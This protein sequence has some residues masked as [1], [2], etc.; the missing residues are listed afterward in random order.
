MRID[1]N[2][3][4]DQVQ[5]QVVLAIPT[6]EPVLVPDPTQAPIATATPTPTP[7]PTPAPTPRPTATPRPT[8]TVQTLLWQWPTA[9]QGQGSQSA[10]D[11]RPTPE[12]TPT[13]EPAATAEYVVDSYNPKVEL[14]QGLDFEV[15]PQPQPL[16][17]AIPIDSR[18]LRIWPIVLII[19]GAIMEVV[20]IGMF[21]RGRTEAWIG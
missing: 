5:T 12:S 1:I 11:S 10:P 3:V 8:P 13:R 21:V 6:P 18:S 2:D 14:S 16:V 4:A 19:I 7:T 15:V 20:S 9:A 17:P